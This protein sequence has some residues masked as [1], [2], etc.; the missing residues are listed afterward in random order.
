MVR[1]CNL[2]L[3]C[4]AVRFSF[5]LG[6]FPTAPMPVQP[7]I[8]PT[9]LRRPGPP[10]P[11]RLRLL[12]GLIL[13]AIPG[14]VHGQSS[15]HASL[16]LRPIGG[17]GVRI[18]LRPAGF[19]KD[20]VATPVLVEPEPPPPLMRV[21]AGEL[22]SSTIVEVGTLRVEVTPAPLTVAVSN[23][24]GGPVQRLTF[25]A[26]GTLAFDL[27]DQPVL[28]LGGGGPSFPS[29]IDWREQPVE[30]D[31]RGRMHPMR[32]DWQRQAYGSRNPV[33]LL[34]G[35]AGWGLYI[36]MPWGAVDLSGPT[37]GRFV[38]LDPDT[39]DLRQQQ[40]LA[41]HFDD[42]GKGLP[43][44]ET[45]VPGYFDIFV[46]DASDPTTAMRDIAAISGPAVL[47][48]KWALGYMQSHRTL[49]ND[50]QMIQ[51][52]D[53]F[54]EK[55]IPLDAVVYLGTGF[56]PRGWNTR[57]PSFDFNPDVFRRD[58]ADVISDLHARHVKVA[59][60]VVPWDR[61]RLPT[62]RGGIP[63]AVDDDIGPGHL[64]N[65]WQ[66]HVPLVEAG[67]D[68]WWP[69]EGDW[70][71]LFERMKRHQL[72]YEGPLSTQ[73]DTRPWS[74]H[75]NGH[76]G[77]A[78]WGGWIW[79]GDTDST[80]KSLEAQIANG[81]NHSLSVGP[82][83][84]TDIGGFFPSAELDGE[85]YARWFQFGAFC[86][87]FRA[88]GQTWQT[89]LPWGWGLDDRGPLE[90]P[91]PPLAESMNNPAIEPIARRYA[92]LR[93][94]LL[95]YNYALAWQARTEGLPFIRALWLHH[96][97]DPRA[98]AT[99]DEFLWGRDLLVAPVYKKGATVREVYLPDGTWYDWWTLARH[100]GGRSIS[101]EVDLATLPLFVRAGAIIPLDPVR[102][103][104][105]QPV[106]EPT[107]LRIFPGADG[108]FTF[109]DDDGH[110]LAYLKGAQTIIELA[111]DDS[112]QTLS[113]NPPANAPKP[114]SP[115]EFAIQLVGTDSIKRVTFTGEPL[116]IRIHRDLP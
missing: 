96:P 15:D 84:G 77:V 86:P 107:T 72:Y 92:E 89:R 35:T 34:W 75:R 13:C 10:S 49:E 87:S 112:M 30:F 97:E 105:A 4:P 90:S 16:D 74:L 9:P 60:H 115:R 71:D 40:G 45:L 54:R 24:A 62:L 73:P 8:S 26:D 12:C 78:R 47:P 46:F 64:A 22:S 21:N 69:D 85:L 109:Y 66:D 61:D 36:P 57:Q 94:Q 91:T 14:S 5:I 113:L 114:T 100:P 42:Y 23:A 7:K 31:R 25:A 103:Y 56:T 88:H 104:T 28:G 33:T 111:W 11:A 101:R 102:Q 2:M 27:D 98:A 18:T 70:F 19:E 52:V 58:P 6:E 41:D 32:P 48:P 81:I 76:L 3:G 59:V 108:R 106:D 1:A 29:E 93:Y 63:P 55:R 68:A 20:F 38:P 99:G 44:V 67:V 53:T 83:W 50:A 37:R 51:I 95:P 80:W 79:S 17:S 110:S 82:Y 43:P 65:Y 39:T 116:S